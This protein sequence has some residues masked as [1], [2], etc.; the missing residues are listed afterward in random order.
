MSK[1]AVFVQSFAL[2]IETR[3]KFDFKGYMSSNGYAI[4]AGDKYG[5]EN[6]SRATPRSCAWIHNVE[7]R[8]P[9]GCGQDLDTSKLREIYA[10]LVLC[11]KPGD[12][13][14]QKPCGG[15]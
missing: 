6:I 9:P 5:P 12:R 10:G 7:M 13:S 1:V 14:G 11:P 2:P 8:A 3:L 15:F 4:V